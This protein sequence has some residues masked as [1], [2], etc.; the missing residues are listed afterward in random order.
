MQAIKTIAWIEADGNL[1]L[2]GLPCKKGSYVEVIIL[3]PDQ[4]TQ[5]QR[6]EALE[7]LQGRADEMNFR[8]NGP[9]PTRD[10]LHERH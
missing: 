5:E 7:R 1:H 10:E 4:P 3:I 2:E 6:Q 8:S 9:Y